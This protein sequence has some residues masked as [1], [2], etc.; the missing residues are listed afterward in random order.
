MPA[1]RLGPL[2]VEAKLGDHPSLSSVWRAVHIQ[3][4]RAVAVKVFPLPFGGTQEARR[5]FAREW[6]QLKK[7]QHPAI[8]R[9]YGG[10]F[11]P[12]EAYLAYE[13][14]EGETLAAQLERRGRLP[15]E[16][17]L[18]LAEPMVDALE[19][20]HGRG[21][22]YGRLFPDKILF[23]GL[24]PVLVDVRACDPDSPFV[25]GRRLSPHELAVR[26]PEQ[27]A[28]PGR[29]TP[30]GDL[31][32]LGA[33][34]YW[35]L[36]GRPPIA[37]DHAD[38]IVA[39]AATDRPPPAASIALD[40]P[41]WLDRLVSQLLEKKPESR[42]HG[43][44]AVRLALAEVRRRAMSRSGVAE[45]ASSGFSPLAVTDQQ[46]KEE[47]RRILG[48][49]L[50]LDDEPPAEAVHW[51]EQGWLLGVTL[52]ALVG[53]LAYAAWPLGE[54]AM[55][56]RAEALMASEIRSDMSRA[57]ISYLEPML[58]KFPGGNHADWASEQIERVEMVEA[59]HALSVKI[60]RNL[61][62]KNEGERLYAEAEQYER[63]GDTATALDRY[64]GMV[65]LLGDDPAYRPFVNLARR[66]IATLERA[67]TGDE[68]AAEIIRKKLSEADREFADGRVV[69][70]RRIWYGIVE[71]YGNHANLA[72]LVARAQDRLSERP[73]SGPAT[74][75]TE[76]NETDRDEEP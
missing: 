73:S 18:E 65:T 13:L 45:H 3:Q 42:P 25:T 74:E 56:E 48:R 37:G 36:T 40:T 53:G 50:V 39:R 72:P 62:L 15:W 52:A 71:L 12:Q 60:K 46:Q 69:A 63:F 67:A 68:E 1:S 30:R 8:A 5:G 33:I 26:P 43:A 31:Y 14:I 10:G 22:V 24:S 17:V 35:S 28:D 29:V 49:E 38:E 41:V 64:R 20:L 16:S 34:L 6:A 51:Y 21:I 76:T 66:Q 54:D 2:A 23:A 47:A 70:A 11:E 19:Y 9:C 44:G 55:R 32:S 61:P 57:R 27:L 58:R 7:V 59:E 75:T 4:R